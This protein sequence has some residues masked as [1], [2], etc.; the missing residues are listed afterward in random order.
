L[1]NDFLNFAPFDGA[2]EIAKDNFGLTA[3]LLTKD[4]EDHQ[5]N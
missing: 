5:K 4:A 1:D 2:H 3:V